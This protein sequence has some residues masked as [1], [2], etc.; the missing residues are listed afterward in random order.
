VQC[1]AYSHQYLE[2][3]TRLINQTI[4]RVPP[5]WTLPEAQVAKI[6]AHPL[7]PWSI[8]YPG[9]N[10][11]IKSEVLLWVQD[12]GR[13]VAAS[14]WTWPETSPPGPGSL[15]WIVA[16]PGQTAA[17]DALLNTIAARAK[18]CGCRELSLGRYAFGVGWLGIPAT[19]AHLIAGLQ[20][21]GWTLQARWVI[22]SGTTENQETSPP[23]AVAHLE[24]AWRAEEASQE[25]DLVLM[26]GDTS[27]GQCQAW[28]IPTHFAACDGYND[29]T[30]IEWLGV[31]PP[32]QRRGLGRWLLCEQLRRQAERGV[33]QAILWTESDNRAMRLL[34][35][36]LGFQAGPECW[37]F[38]KTID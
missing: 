24:L 20:D 8:R 7:Q 36:S 10:E 23:P 13:L 32:Y 25:W 11:R 6:I 34:A 5:G 26:D 35:E 15:S 3:L 19:Q 14:Q 12:Q 31:E 27:V 2:H 21:A 1:V 30:T 16:E 17:L 29:W 18:A 33:R 9:Q 22:I 37:V 28:G 4:E 38:K